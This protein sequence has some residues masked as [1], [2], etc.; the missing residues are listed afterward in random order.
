MALRSDLR[1]LVVDDMSVSRQILA[2]MLDH[3][4]ISRVTVASDGEDGLQ[5]L[6][7]QVV[8][9]VISDLNKTARRKSPKHSD[10]AWT[11]CW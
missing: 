3:L 10:L 2:Q 11:A 5:V 7:K 8:D 9:L 4:G 6:L 1:V